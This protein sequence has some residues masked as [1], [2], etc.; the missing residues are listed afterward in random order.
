VR[1]LK[2]GTFMGAAGVAAGLADTV[3]APDAAFA[4]LLAEIS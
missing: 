2:A 4:A 1:G 3:M